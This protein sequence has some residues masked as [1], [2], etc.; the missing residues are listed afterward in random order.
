MTCSTS[1]ITVASE[2]NIDVRLLDLVG[3]PFN[4]IIFSGSMEL[5]LVLRVSLGL[6]AGG[7]FAS[8]PALVNLLPKVKH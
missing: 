4:S 6:D 3:V 1:S 7:D 8:E 2:G 5:A